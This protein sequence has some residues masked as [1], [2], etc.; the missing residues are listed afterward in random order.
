MQRQAQRNPAGLGI[1]T[2]G[3]A[4]L[5]DMLKMRGSGISVGRE[6]PEVRRRMWSGQVLAKYWALQLPA[7][8]IVIV[9]LI[10]TE[11]ALGLPRWA[12]WTI[13]VAW[14]SKDAVLYPLVWRSYDPGY[15]AIGPYR[16]EGAPGVAVGRIDPSGLVIV[17]GE[18]WRAELV[19]GAR[20]IEEG[21]SVRVQARHGLTLLVEP[22]EG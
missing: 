1:L 2:L 12:F 10:L 17:S 16:M 14:V 3:H 22:E 21:E 11:E 6:G 18:L 5:P 13:V 19:Q 15:P 7:T 20:S 9:V 8:A 4:Q